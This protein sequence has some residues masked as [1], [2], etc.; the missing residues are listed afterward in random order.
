MDALDYIEYGTIALLYRVF[1]KLIC[2][3][4][5]LTFGNE[6]FRYSMCIFF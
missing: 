1:D 2:F 6:S 3:S 5:L 4:E